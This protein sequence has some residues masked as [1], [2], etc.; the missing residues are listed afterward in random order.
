MPR[1]AHHMVV[2][3]G[4]DAPIRRNARAG[5]GR[6]VVGY[7]CGVD[8]P[9]GRVDRADVRATED[10]LTLVLSSG[11]VDV[12]QVRLRYHDGLD[13]MVNNAGTVATAAVNAWALIDHDLSLE[14]DEPSA[15]SLGVPSRI[16]LHL[17]VDGDAIR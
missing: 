16:R 10:E 14:L 1:G 12:L 5:G 2:T 15:A 11:G 13:E 4:R 8:S 17:D 3:A 6:C 9:P 7:G